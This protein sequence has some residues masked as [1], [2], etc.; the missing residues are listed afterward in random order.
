MQT[1]SQAY[2]SVDTLM[3]PTS[4]PPTTMPSTTTI[5]TQV[6]PLQPSNTDST[7]P[8]DIPTPRPNADPPDELN[9][10]SATPTIGIALDQDNLIPLSDTSL[11]DKSVTRTASPLN[12]T[13][14]SMRSQRPTPIS[15]MDASDYTLVCD[16]RYKPA[17]K[18]LK[19]LSQQQLNAITQPFAKH[20]DPN[21]DNAIREL[22]LYVLSFHNVE[23]PSSN[24]HDSFSLPLRWWTTAFAALFGKGNIPFA[25]TNK[26]TLQVMVGKLAITRS[27]HII[28]E[29]DKVAKTVSAPNR[30]A[31]AYWAACLTVGVLYYFK[32]DIK[33]LLQTSQSK[34]TKHMTGNPKLTQFFKPVSSTP[35]NSRADPETPRMGPKT[36]SEMLAPC[37]PNET[38]PMDI[39]SPPT[40]TNISSCNQTPPPPM[41]E[42]DSTPKMVLRKSLPSTQAPV[43]P[44]DGFTSVKA[45]SKKKTFRHPSELGFCR[46]KFSMTLPAEAAPRPELSQAIKTAGLKL[47]VYTYLRA[48]IQELLTLYQSHD[49]SVYLLPWAKTSKNTPIHSP[50]LLPRTNE[51]FKPYVYG[52]NSPSWNKKAFFSLCLSYDQKDTSLP[53]STLFQSYKGALEE[54]LKAKSIWCSPH[55]LQESDDEVLLGFL[56]FTGYFIDTKRL[57]ECFHQSYQGRSTIVDGNAHGRFNM[58]FTTGFFPP[59]KYLN[60]EKWVPIN[61]DQGNMTCCTVTRPKAQIPVLVYAHKAHAQAC[62]EKLFT[63][64]QGQPNFLDKP[65]SYDCDVY[66]TDKWN[67]AGNASSSK[68]NASRSRNN[69]DQHVRMLKQ[70]VVLSTS[71]ITNLDQPVRVDE[72]PGMISAN[73]IYAESRKF[74]QPESYPSLLTLRN[75]LLTIPYPLRDGGPSPEELFRSPRQK[76]IPNC[77]DRLFHSVDY[78]S[79]PN[80]MGQSILLSCVESRLPVASSFIAALPSFIHTFYNKGYDTWVAPGIDIDAHRCQFQFDEDGMWTGL[81]YSPDDIYLQASLDYDLPDDAL[82]HSSM[83]DITSNDPNPFQRPPVIM[84]AVMAKVDTHLAAKEVKLNAIAARSAANTQD[85]DN[86]SVATMASFASITS[87]HTAVSLES[88]SKRTTSSTTDNP[89]TSS[90][91]TPMDTDAPPNSDDASMISNATGRSDLTLPTTVIPME[92]TILTPL[93]TI[94]AAVDLTLMGQQSG[95]TSEAPPPTDDMSVMSHSTLGTAMSLPPSPGSAHYEQPSDTPPTLN[96]PHVGKSY[97]QALQNTPSHPSAS[98]SDPPIPLALVDSEQLA[99]DPTSDS[100]HST[101]GLSSASAKKRKQSVSPMKN[102][103]KKTKA[104]KPPDSKKGSSANEVRKG[105]PTRSLWTKSADTSQ[106]VPIS[107]RKPGKP[108]KQTTGTSPGGAGAP[109]PNV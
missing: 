96:S 54:E 101:G 84:D 70:L 18:I 6:T 36:P 93:S 107:K 38:T 77:S 32:D 40:L 37:P 19:S 52:L 29:L 5:P 25:M 105:P 100:S 78:S 87:V 4:M 41:A 45:R 76:K 85:D 60:N 86:Q 98:G 94:P 92:T 34:P 49:S 27:F 47:S 44:P 88:I 89:Q 7:P 22:A 64:F 48:M 1:F 79:N 42:D 106:V 15:H 17:L 11:L 23:D 65:G 71:V 35:T 75:I 26:E 33:Q 63:L 103:H 104:K 39:D 95:D 80:A 58:C 50:D 69:M 2:N 67:N 20:G 51:A 102:P 66:F 72:P 46:V 99:N 81:W 56:R 55:A 14:P 10:Q 31:K 61:T 97:A 24:A 59:L 13:S 21:L 83:A 12:T 74:S 30:S 109:G 57:T 108:W 43:V 3:P 53:G 90:A 28:P 62:K 82:L 16:K 68:D 8:Q 9:T 91:S 73:Y